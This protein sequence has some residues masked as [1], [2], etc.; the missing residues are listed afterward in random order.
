MIPTQS[1]FANIIEKAVLPKVGTYEKTRNADDTQTFTAADLFFLSHQT[2]KGR[3][4]ILKHSGIVW[5][6]HCNPHLLFYLQFQWSYS[7]FYSVFKINL[8]QRW[9]RRYFKTD[10]RLD[11]IFCSVLLQA[12]L[13][14]TARRVMRRR[15]RTCTHIHIN[16][17]VQCSHT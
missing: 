11:N 9:S 1:I 13:L 8:F 3:L 7:A 16:S 6:H 14:L 10:M 2:N 15:L 4:R 17:A 5:W 12:R